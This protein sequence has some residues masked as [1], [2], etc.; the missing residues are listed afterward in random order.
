MEDKKLYLLDLIDKKL[1]Q[2]LQD[3][4]ASAMNVA[5]LIYDTEKPV[6]EPSEFVDFCIK[7]TRGS[8]IGA[9]M[10][11]NCDLKWGKIAADS[12]KP[13]IYN[14]HAG[15]VDFV[16]PIIV[17]NQHIGSF[18][19]GQILFEPPNENNIRELAREIGVDENEY[20]EAARKV[21]IVSEDNIRAAINLLYIVTNTI[22]AIAHKNLELKRKNKRDQLYK[23]IVKIIRSTLDINEVKEK[24]VTSLGQALEAD[25][26]F[27]MDYDKVKDTFLIVQY[28]Y[29]SSKNIPSYVGANVN[30]DVPNFMEELKKGKSLIIDNRKVF[31]NNI[32]IEYETEKNTIEKAN[33][34]SAFGIPILYN[35]ELYSVLGLHY[36]NKEHRVSKEELDLLASISEQ[37]ALAISQAMLYNK[38]QEQA[39]RENLLRNIL[40][41]ALTTFDLNQMKQIVSEIG[42]LTK[43]DKCYFVEVSEDERRGKEIHYEWEYLASPDIKSA[44]G[45]T[46]PADEVHKFVEMYLKAKDLIVFD[47][48]EI[49]KNTD[50]QFEDMHKYVNRFD[51]KSGIGI[52]LFYKDKLHAVLAIEYIKEKILPTED[53]LE[54]YRLFGNQ[55]GMVL[56]QIKLFENTKKTAEREKLLRNIIE[57]IRSSLEIK[58]TLSFICEEVSKLFNVQRVTV[59][60][61][62]DKNNL[63]N[64]IIRKEYK[65]NVEVKGL[66]DIDYLKEAGSYNGKTILQEGKNLIVDNINEA[67][68]PDYY[69][70]TYKK[71]GVKSI[72]SVPVKSGENFFGI[73]FLSATNEY[74]KWKEDDVKLLETI[75]AQIYIAIKQAELFEKEKLAAERERISRNIIEILRSSIDKAIIKKLFVKNIGKFFNAD[76]VIFSEYDNKLGVYLPVDNDSEYLSSVEEKSYIGFDWSNPNMQLW[77][78]PLLEKREIKIANWKDYVNQG[79][80]VNDF[81]LSLYEESKIKSKYGFPIIYQNNLLGFFCL[82]FTKEAFD[83]SDED[84][85]RIRSICTQAGIAIYHANLYK[86]AQ[87]C[88]QYKAALKEKLLDKIEKPTQEILNASVILSQNEFEHE[89]ELEHLNSIIRSCNQ[90]IELT[91]YINKDLD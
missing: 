49:L 60:E 42:K 67:D 9:K 68:L 23:N 27:I 58:E 47:Y 3:N 48:E 71:M 20:V 73:I 21:K 63:Q 65:R 14:C 10:C 88:N 29:L 32:P 11:Q 7:Y 43:A 38:T 54:F 24:I 45:Y 74:R 18:F 26:C 46:F 2:E 59:V 25:R 30:Q 70:E 64:W 13:V 81:I 31:I 52:P 39:R 79:H 17:E 28:E 36:I 69:K 8:K 12:G 44:I 83:L 86:N 87:Q 91:A 75:A 84:I 40:S 41:K 66:N 35:G 37:I 82:E 55:A 56:N 76:R 77:I 62:Y 51:L 15:L 61:F 57:K 33:V 1:L 16:V 4:F 89:V 85:G 78:K 22:S 53:E 72:L 34:N 50:G 80:E 5:S 90:L 19:G 6:T